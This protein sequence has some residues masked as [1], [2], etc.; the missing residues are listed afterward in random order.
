MLSGLLYALR[1]PAPSTSGGGRT[2]GC[3]ALA[4]PRVQA[5]ETVSPKSEKGQMY[6]ATSYGPEA[7]REVRSASMRIR[8]RAWAGKL[9]PRSASN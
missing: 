4:A 2:G 5:V 7:A 9:G 3:S 8:C 1:V 6:A